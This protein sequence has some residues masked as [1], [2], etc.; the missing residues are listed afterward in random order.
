M[1]LS[2]WDNIFIGPLNFIGPSNNPELPNTHDDLILSD[3]SSTQEHVEIDEDITDYLNLPSW[4]DT[5]P[6]ETLG[7]EDFPSSWRLGKCYRHSTIT[8]IMKQDC[9]NWIVGACSS[10]A[11]FSHL[12][13]GVNRKAIN[14][15]LETA[16]R[17]KLFNSSSGRITCLDSIAKAEFKSHIDTAHYIV[18]NSPCISA[19][20][21]LVNKLH[22]E[23][24]ERQGRNVDLLQPVSKSTIYKLL[25]ESN[26]VMC[27]EP[28]RKTQVRIDAESNIRNFFSWAVCLNCYCVGR[29]A[30]MIFNWDWTTFSCQNEKHNQLGVYVS[31][32]VM[33]KDVYRLPVQ[34]KSSGS[35]GLYIKKGILTNARGH[36]AHPVYIIADQVI[37]F[38]YC[39][40]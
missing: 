14:K 31:A 23:T 39:F 3:S 35:L 36:S 4:T 25:H 32:E 20:R 38:V 40:V 12:I 27:S 2:D 7:M 26:V 15:W 16:S 37:N 24:A 18:R 21:L 34:T 9:V 1:D 13:S 10:G 11:E 6:K 33:Q 8:A 30:E 19:I 29:I 5:S 22:K 28:Q 17:N